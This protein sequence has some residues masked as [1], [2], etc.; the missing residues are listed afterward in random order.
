MPNFLIGEPLIGGNFFF[1]P[2]GL[3]IIP[4]DWPISCS[5]AKEVFRGG[6]GPGRL[7]REVQEVTANLISKMYLLISLRKSTPPQNRLHVVHNYL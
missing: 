1:L 5:F 7:C 4:A 6:R 2:I 3:L